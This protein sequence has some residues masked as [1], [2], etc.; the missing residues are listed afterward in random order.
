MV[1]F[2]TV[3]ERKR[4]G[5]DIYQ[6]P[7]DGKE[8]ITT[9]QINDIFLLGLNHEEVNW[10]NPNYNLLK[11][12]L[13]KIQSLSEMYYEFRLSSN[14]T[15]IKDTKSNVYKRIQSFKGWISL[16]PIKVNINSIGLIK[17]I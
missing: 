15:Q 12:S 8:I 1:T 3:V 6:L 4:Q 5:Q 7:K 17:K 14:S 2:W 16:N 10:E 9:L 11:D 13:F